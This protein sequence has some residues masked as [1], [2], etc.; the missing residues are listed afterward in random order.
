M[1]YQGQHD[2]RADLFFLTSSQSLCD[3]S[4]LNDP[5]NKFYLLIAFGRGP[6]PATCGGEDH[7]RDNSAQIL[8][9]IGKQPESHSLN[10]LG[11]PG[12]WLERIGPKLALMQDFSISHCRKCDGSAGNNPIGHSYI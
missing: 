1:R 8:V 4:I 9:Q 6:L 7:K 5:G 2:G 12:G 11:A 3:L 10:P